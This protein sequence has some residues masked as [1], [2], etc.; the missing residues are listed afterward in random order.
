MSIGFIGRHF[1]RYFIMVKNFVSLPCRPIKYLHTVWSRF[2][3]RV[4][5]VTIFFSILLLISFFLPDKET[6]RN[7]IFTLMLQNCSKLF[8]KFNSKKMCAHQIISSI[9]VLQSILKIEF[10]LSE[11]WNARR[12]PN[13]FFLRFG[14]VEKNQNFWPFKNGNE[15]DESRKSLELFSVRILKF[16]F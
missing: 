1:Y 4:I 12:W 15:K 6:H 16:D 3:D 8:A 11:S 2:Y 14:Q 7:A 9:P 10:R 13:S 5:T